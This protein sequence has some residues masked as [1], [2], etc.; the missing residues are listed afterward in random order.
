MNTDELRELIARAT[1]GPWHLCQHLKSMEADQGCSCGYRGVIFGPDKDVAYAIC[2]PGHEPAPE[3]QE[4]TEPQ[5]Y[6]RET[7]LVNSALIVAA[8]NA[9]PELL[10]RSDRLAAIEAVEVD[11]ALKAS[12]WRP[13]SEGGFPLGPGPRNVLL[14]REGRGAF[15]GQYIHDRHAEHP[16]PWFTDGAHTREHQQIHPP[17]HYKPLGP[18]P[19][20]LP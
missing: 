4:G 17:T 2:Q 20:E 10:D 9:L 1:P 13:I 11:A 16:H 15:V 12:E 5:R 19:E 6:P 8:I 3:G 14:W 7:E 18:G